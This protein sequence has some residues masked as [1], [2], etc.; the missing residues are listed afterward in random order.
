MKYISPKTIKANSAN[1]SQCKTL[2]AG[3]PT[4]IPEALLA[5]ALIKGA[6]PHVEA[7]VAATPAED[8]PAVKTH[9]GDAAVEAIAD[10][11]EAI[12]AEGDP[13]LLTAAGMPRVNILEERLGFDTTK[14]QRDEAWAIAEG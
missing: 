2:L 14:T 5:D 4:E 6:R 9:D 8:T 12:M 10:M 11:M 13:E 7:P 3:V 1:G